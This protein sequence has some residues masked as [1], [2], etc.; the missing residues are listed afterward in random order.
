MKKEQY[1]RII[2]YFEA[3][4]WRS[5]ILEGTAKILPVTTAA[6]YLCFAALLFI[7]KDPRTWSF[8]LVPALTFV[9][10]T[11][12]RK[13]INRPRPYD[14]LGYEP[15]LKY[16]EGKGQS[17]PSRHTASAWII[18]FACFYVHPVTGIIMILIALAVSLSRILAGMHYISDVVAGFLFSV[19]AAIIG[20]IIF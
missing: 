16:K 13:I 3:S 8:S 6:I 18:A 14:T 7:F 1:E 10:V 15:F 11:C 19:V 20:F 5:L 4:K 2:A 9:C 17:F 12:I